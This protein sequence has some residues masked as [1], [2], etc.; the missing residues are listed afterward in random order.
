LYGTAKANAKCFG[1]TSYRRRK[2]Y[3]YLRRK[4]VNQV[5]VRDEDMS[6]TSDVEPSVVAI[7]SLVATSTLATYS[8]LY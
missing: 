6:G 2:R 7:F 1:L 5:Q 3:V 4:V 8:L